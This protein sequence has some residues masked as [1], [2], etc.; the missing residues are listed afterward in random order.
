MARRIWTVAALQPRSPV[1][2]HPLEMHGIDGV[3]LAL[4]PVARHHGEHDLHEAVIPAEW[5][6]VRQQ[7]CR[8]GPQ[9]GPDQ[10]R[11]RRH[12]IGLDA[13]LIAE[14]YFRCVGVLEW[15]LAA[16]TGFVEPP[17]MI[18]AAQAALLD[19]AVRQI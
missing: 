17:A 5:L 2:V 13:D 15:L 19:D 4:E 1:V 11:L 7:R 10:A 9:I 14:A 18:A 8:I 3:F 16:C 12:A 6:P